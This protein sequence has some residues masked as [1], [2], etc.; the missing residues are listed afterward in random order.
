MH[1]CHLTI[2]FFFVKNTIFG[3]I[4]NVKNKIKTYIFNNQNEKKEAIK[5][6][7]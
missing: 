4:V 6:I 1:K 2:E 7:I 5:K 3:L